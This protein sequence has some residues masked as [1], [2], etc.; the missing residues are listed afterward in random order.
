MLFCHVQYCFSELTFLGHYQSESVKMF[1]SRSGLTFCL[2]QS[3][4]I[5]TR[6]VNVRKNQLHE[7]ELQLSY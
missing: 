2:A 7:H 4:Y 1:G 5:V 6:W 3:G